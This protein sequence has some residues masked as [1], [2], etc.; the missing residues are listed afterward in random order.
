MNSSRGRVWR[1]VVGLLGAGLFSLVSPRAAQSAQIEGTTWLLKGS[2]TA[3]IWQVVGSRTQAL[4]RASGRGPV[5]ARFLDGGVL[6]LED[7]AHYVLTGS[8]NLDPAGKLTFTIS[9]AD[10]ERFLDENLPSLIAQYIDSYDV[11]T[12]SSSTKLTAKDDVGSLTYSLSFTVNVVVQGVTLRLKYAMSA[13]GSNDVSGQAPV[14][15]QWMF[16]DCDVRVSAGRKVKIEQRDDLRLVIGPA[17]GLAHDRFSMRRAADDTELYAGYYTL[18]SSK[19]TLLPDEDLLEGYFTAA[20]ADKADEVY[21]GAYLF[22]EGV[23]PKVFTGTIDRHGVLK[24]NGKARLP[25]SFDT[26]DPRTGEWKERAFSGSH[27]L[28]GNGVQIH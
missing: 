19:L 27:S 26:E 15:S 17:G 20:I 7:A 24:L 3:K 25:G 9:D 13:R 18:V 8:W 23:V 16:E 11:R 28:K 12:V 2:G 14:G 4:A 5:L 21:P 22:L 1:L 10:I 6:E